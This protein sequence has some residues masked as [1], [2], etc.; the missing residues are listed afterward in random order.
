MFSLHLKGFKETEC[1][2]VSGTDA[3]PSRLAKVQGTAAGH[4]DTLSPVCL[5]FRWLTPVAQLMS[6]PY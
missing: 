5:L 6:S 1:V 2:R 4:M 3:G